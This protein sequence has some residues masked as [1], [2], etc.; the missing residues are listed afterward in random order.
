MQLSLLIH[1]TDKSWSLFR[2]KHR[3]LEGPDL[4]SRLLSRSF[5]GRVR[6]G[7]W[8]PLSDPKASGT[9]RVP[10]HSPPGLCGACMLQGSPP[11]HPICHRTA[12][13]GGCGP[14]TGCW[15]HLANLRLLGWREALIQPRRAL[16]CF[17][18]ISESHIFHV[19]TAA[20]ER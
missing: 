19:R 14:C 7:G 11:L 15:R 16:M 4:C 2:D 5:Q 12:R 20:A 8:L 13:G 6:Q 1:T 3:P 10:S 17:M 18:R 9:Q